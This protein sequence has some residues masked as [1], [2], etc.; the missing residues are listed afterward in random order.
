M[1]YLLRRANKQEQKQADYYSSLAS[2]FARAYWDEITE[3]QINNARCFRPSRK[4][5]EDKLFRMYYALAGIA[6][7]KATA[8]R[9]CKRI[10]PGDRTDF[11]TFMF[12]VDGFQSPEE[13]G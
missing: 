6:S 1:T 13:L 12:P 11:P 5:N 7:E 10:N 3:F 2:R 8:L 9:C 4:V